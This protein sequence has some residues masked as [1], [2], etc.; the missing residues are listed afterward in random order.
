MLHVG[1]KSCMSQAT[2]HPEDTLLIQKW[3]QFMQ[4]AW[5]IFGLDVFL[6]PKVVYLMGEGC[7]LNH[8]YNGELCL[9]P[10]F[11]ACSFTRPQF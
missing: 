10:F 2:S 11:Y 3:T 9:S 6:V 5:F 7:F 4:L 8:P 1:M